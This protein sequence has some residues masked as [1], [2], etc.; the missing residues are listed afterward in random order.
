MRRLSLA[1]LAGDPSSSSFISEL[2]A[3][4]GSWWCAQQRLPAHTCSAHAMR[5]PHGMQQTTP[6]PTS[7]RCVR[8]FQ[9]KDGYWALTRG[10]GPRVMFHVP[11]RSH[12][13]WSRFLDSMHST[14][15][16]SSDC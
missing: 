14:A 11:V 9:A 4:S 10:I 13:V 3:F 15:G 2:G 12:T 16:F 6:S 7:V 5:A 8:G 1:Q